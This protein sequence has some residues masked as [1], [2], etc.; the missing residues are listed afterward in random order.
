MHVQRAANTDTAACS[1]DAARRTSPTPWLHAVPGA[2][3]ALRPRFPRP[4][5]IHYLSFPMRWFHT[6]PHCTQP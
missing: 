5:C 2:P 3:L 1:P 4:Y 6:P